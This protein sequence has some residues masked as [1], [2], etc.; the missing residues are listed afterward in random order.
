MTTNWWQQAVA[1]PNAEVRQQAQ[2]R[3]NELT[4]PQGSLGELEHIAIQIASLQGK[5]KPEI[6]QPTMLIF[7]AD[8]GV[9]AQGVSA[10]PQSVTIAMLDN[11]VRGGAAVSVLCKAQGIQ[12]QVINCGT[13]TSC[14]HLGQIVHQSIASGTADFSQ[15]AAMTTEQALLALV[16][17]KKQV[18]QAVA[19]GCDFLLAGEMGI[20][21]TSAASALSALL[22][23]A[24]VASLT[25]AGTGMVG[26]SLVH[27]T[28]VILRSV[29]RAKPFV[30]SPLEALEQLGGFEIGALTGAY[31]RAAQLGIPVLVDGFITTAAALLAVKLNPAVR[32]WLLF[33]HQSAEAGHQQLIAALQGQPLLNL[34]MRLG[35]GSGAATAFALIKNAL[36]IHNEMATF[37]EAAIESNADLKS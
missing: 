2:M 21:N 28:N 17:G 12:L 11:F 18:E 9:V 30:H 13:A 16:L 32:P 4:K 14:E 27:K 24:D 23:D 29:E 15:M 34:N 10:F 19:S 5:L 35:E 1:V 7:A 31:L 26:A 8:H 20:G 25:G 22:L 36:A 3:Q 33:A 6:K 37:S